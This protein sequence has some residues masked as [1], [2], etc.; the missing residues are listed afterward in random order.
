MN[1]ATTASATQKETT[2]PIARTVQSMS[3]HGQGSNRGVGGVL[4][5]RPQ[6]LE[7]IVTSRDHH[8]WHGKKEGELQRDRP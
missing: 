7:K 5:M 8:D 3:V 6:S 2:S 4:R 1:Q